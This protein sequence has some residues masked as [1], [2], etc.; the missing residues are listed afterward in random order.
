MKKPCLLLSAI[1]FLLT[2]APAARAQTSGPSKVILIEREELKPGKFEEHLRESNNFARM[3]AH[4]RTV[5][6]PSYVRVGMSPI[7]GN[8]NEVL[9]LYTF[10]SFAQWAQSQRDIERWMTKPGPMRTFFERV[11]GPPQQGEDLH[12]SVRSMVASFNPML[13]HN[14]RASLAKARYLSV[15]TFRVKPGHYGDF[16]RATQMYKGALGKMKGDHHFAVYE[17]M[18]GGRDGM[19]LILS[20]MESLAE[21]DQQMAA[22]DEFPKAM[23]EKLDDFERLVSATLDPSDTVIYAING[24]MSN[25]PEEFIKAD[26]T[27]W[28]QEMPVATTTTTVSAPRAGAGRR[29]PR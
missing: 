17:V 6:E 10:D 25:P 23:G 14:P 29:R 26:P 8:A 21:M 16:I 9:Y 28:S 1:C 2:V 12:T 24:R 22:G 11:T 18:G 15:S 13:S 27:F 7:A 3:L 20:S 5:N 19:F 4:A